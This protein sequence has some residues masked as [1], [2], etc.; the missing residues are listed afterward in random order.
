[1]G[2]PAVHFEEHFGGVHVEPAQ[3]RTH[4][5]AA[6]AFA[7]VHHH[8]DAPREMELRRDLLH[9]GRH[10]IRRLLAAFAALQVARLDR[11]AN[12]LN[13]FPMNR[14]GPAHHLEAVKLRRIVAA[15]NHHPAVGAQMKYRVVEHRRGRHPEVGHV[16]TAGHQAAQ[17]HVAQA[18]RAQPRIAAQIDVPAAVPQQVR[19]ESLP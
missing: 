14:R 7:R 3:D 10:R 12:L 5:R 2:K 16:A 13:G 8:A 15:G 17:Q 4:H 9:V 6:G 19:A 11:A 1:M 18:R